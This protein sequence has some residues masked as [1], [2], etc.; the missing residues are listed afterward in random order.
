MDNNENNSQE[1]APQ[2][3]G[4]TQAPDSQGAASGG[5]DNGQYSG[6]FQSSSQ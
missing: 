3:G 2:D 4:Y 1:F 6:G 5:Q